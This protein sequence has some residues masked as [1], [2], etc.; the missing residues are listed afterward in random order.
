MS[1]DL[2]VSPV[3]GWEVR[4]VE[5]M[6][7][8]LLQFRFVSTPFQGP[9]ETQTTPLLVV[10]SEQARELIELLKSV[11]DKVESFAI[12]SSSGLKH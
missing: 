5:V 3:T 11:L 4:T 9:G 2:L 12:S 8:L 6:Q 7:A 1:E 10:T